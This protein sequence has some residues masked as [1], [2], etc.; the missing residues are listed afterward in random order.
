MVL[1]KTHWYLSISSTWD[2][3]DWVAMFFRSKQTAKISETAFVFVSGSTF[4]TS[5]LDRA[6]DFPG[7]WKFRYSSLARCDVLFLPELKMM[8][9]LVSQGSDAELGSHQPSSSS[10]TSV[11]VSS[12]RY[13]S[14]SPSRRLFCLL[15]AFDFLATLF[16]WILYAHVSKRLSLI[17]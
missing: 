17:F 8:S 2:V 5:L 7:P 13:R 15:A 16:I 12:G 1:L 10:H 14:F 9:S 6:R 11:L 3:A 4:V